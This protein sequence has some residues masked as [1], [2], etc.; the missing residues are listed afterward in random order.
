MT[1]P[2][3]HP[4]VEVVLRLHATIYLRTVPKATSSDSTADDL[5]GA[6]FELILAAVG[7]GIPGAGV[8][9]KWATRKLREERERR[10]ST[11]LH[12]VEMRTN[13]S[14]EDIGAA[15][16]NDPALVP[17]AIRL[18]YAAGMNGHDRALSAMGT[19]FGDAMSDR[20]F[21]EECDLILSVLADLTESHARVLRLLSQAVPGRDNRY[22]SWSADE[23]AEHSGLSRR[24][25]ILCSAALV[26]RGLARTPSG[27]VG[28]SGTVYAITEL[29]GV[30]LEVLSDYSH[31]VD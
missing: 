1:A 16:T 23:L 7:L 20:T 22:W 10:V 15:I 5:G 24:A 30:V 14:R 6:A 25:A 21:I 26:A 28:G 13:R 12:A 17:L 4:R 3:P 19:A 31:A 18:L 27:I 2:P 29:G 11:A 8:P 9:A